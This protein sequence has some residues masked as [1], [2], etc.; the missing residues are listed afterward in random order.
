MNVT[1]QQL[2]LV[3]G[4]G[5]AGTLSRF[6]IAVALPSTR[7]PW[8][9]TVVNLTGALMFGLLWGAFEAAQAP[10]GWYVL[11]LSG[12]MGAFTTFSTWVFEIV[13][14]LGQQRVVI[15]ITHLVVH[16]VAGLGLVWLGAIL[17]RMIRLG[18][19]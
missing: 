13:Q 14:A 5:A 11:L 6:L 4:G 9:T 16:L 15:G 1:W 8:G 18:V 12:F 3:V 7:Y 2:A 19:S 17:G 10:R